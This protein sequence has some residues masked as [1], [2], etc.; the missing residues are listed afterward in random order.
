MFHVRA[1]KGSLFEP[2][3]LVQSRWSRQNPAGT[4]TRLEIMKAEAQ[5][6]WHKLFSRSGSRWFRRLTLEG[7][8]G[9]VELPIEQAEDAAQSLGTRFP[10]QRLG[11]RWLRLPAQVEARDVRLVFATE[12][13]FVRLD[14]TSFTL[15]EIESGTIEVGRVTVRQPWLNRS[16]LKVR[17]TTSLDEA[18]ITLANLALEPGVEIRTFVVQ[19]DELAKGHLNLALVVSAFGGEISAQA[20]TIRLEKELSFEMSGNFSAIRVAPLATFLGRTEAAGGTIRDGHFTFRGLPRQLDTATATLRLDATDFQWESRQWDAM[21][22]GATLMNRHVQILEWHLQQ[23]ENN[24]RLSGDFALPEPGRSWWQSEFTC[25]IGAKIENLTELSALILPEFRFAAGRATVNGTI[26]GQGERFNGQLIIAGSAL[27]WRNAPIENLHAALLLNGNE[28]QVTNVE[29]FNA[30]DYVRG[31]GVVNI[32][33]PRQYWGELRASVDNLAHYAAILQKPIIPE[34]LAGGA[35]IDW[36]GEGSAKGQSGKFSARLNKVRSLGALATQLHPINA[37]LDG[38]YSPGQIGFSKFRLSDDD[39]TFTANVRVADKA[40]DLQGIRLIHKKQLWLEGDALLPFDIA[41]AWP[42]TSL[43]TLLND[44][45]VSKVNLTANDMELGAASRLIGWKFPL[46][47]VLRGNLVADGALD[48]LQ[49]SGELSLK[50][51]RI[52]LSWSGDELNQV[53]AQARFAGKQLVLTQLTAQHPSGAYKLEGTIGFEQL[54]NLTLNLKLQSPSAAFSCFR[55]TSIEAAV[56]FVSNLALQIEG[57]AS[58]PLVSGEADI[59]EVATPRL[60]ELG[61]FWN[62]TEIAE[63]PP[64]FTLPASPWR[65]WRFDVK[66]HTR[67]PRQLP[68]GGLFAADARVTGTG[69][70]P[71]LVGSL[72]VDGMPVSVNRI[73]LT[74]TS[75]ITYADESARAQIIAAARGTLYGEPL[76]LSL[77]GPLNHPLRLVDAAPPLTPEIVHTELTTPFDA[78]TAT[79][80]LRITLHS[81]AALWQGTTVSEWKAMSLLP[82]EPPDEGVIKEVLN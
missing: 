45:T 64:V 56:T 12:G 79:P 70:Q 8:S 26:R 10:G 39:S 24:L 2:V 9:K 50:G 25:A 38:H 53:E 1:V 51:G 68:G 65:D 47:G 6:E 77:V 75:Q 63:V 22:L 61:G 33:G 15:S 30:G 59:R 28:L 71:V 76:T 78:E 18:K 14:E 17:G 36:S 20:R 43:S 67:E 19:A 46:A 5:F 21:K 41:S 32:L 35:V 7:V 62:A 57:P 3:V 31:R 73:P 55:R 74:L 54:R 13:D 37:E 42:N 29:I 16:F 52:P 82:D 44:T 27:K 11:S 4:V 72:T 49:T 48:A 58:A 40:L 23:G 60:P 34:P 66:T 81:P 80:T 69:L